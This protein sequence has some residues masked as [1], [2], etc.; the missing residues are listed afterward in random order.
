MQT[1]SSSQLSC[2]SQGGAN[3]GV[4]YWIRSTQHTV[5]SAELLGKHCAGKTQNVMPVTRTG[6]DGQTDVDCDNAET[7]KTK[8][9]IVQRRTAL[10]AVRWSYART[11][12][13]DR[14][15]IKIQT[16]VQ[17]N[18][19]FRPTDGTVIMRSNNDSKAKRGPK[20]VYSLFSRGIFFAEVTADVFRPSQS[21]PR[22]C[23]RRHKI[24]SDLSC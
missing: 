9:I 14:V 23:Y 7:S 15:L 21:D 22:T 18:Y 6:T 12:I 1:D 5:H 2:V 11:Q 19:T 17:H 10:L 16:I 13:P 8:R 20:S 24:L 3:F 4:N